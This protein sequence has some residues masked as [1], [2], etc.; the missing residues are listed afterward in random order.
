MR[1]P[2]RVGLIGCGAAAS[3]YHAPALR[4]LEREGVVRIVTLVDPDPRSLGELHAVFPA[5]STM[6]DPSALAEL[7]LAIVA[8]PPRFHAEHTIAAL[9]AGVAVL[10]E[11]PMAAT[12]AEGEAMIAAAQSAGKTLAVGLHRRFLP[13][14]RTLDDV[15]RSGRLGTL[16][17]FRCAEGAVFRWPARSRAFF[18]RDAGGGVLADI[19]VHVLDLLGA[20]F[21]SPARVHYEDD[22]MGG[23]EANCRITL[24]YAQGFGGEVR[25][26]RD[27]RQPNR[28]VFD[29][30]HGWIAWHVHDGDRIAM[31]MDGVALGLDAT[32]RD[33]VDTSPAP[34]LGATGGGFETSFVAQ[35]R[36]VVA[37]VRDGTPPLVSGAA[38]LESLRV[39]EACRRERTLMD[40]PWLG[41]GEVA[42]A[43]RLGGV[44]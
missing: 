2:V 3:R 4:V 11:K 15:L 1:E 24:E 10:C 36:D 30:S 21:G 26:S 20:W 7:D 29:C 22:A 31:A 43:R 14:A 5:A 16:R 25:L 41:A 32:L 8:S 18:E 42:R 9:R 17:S 23:V 40:M 38:G 6:R 28:W 37:A 13:A 39:I 19:G 12:V 33:V 27:T 34:G 35:L 44:A